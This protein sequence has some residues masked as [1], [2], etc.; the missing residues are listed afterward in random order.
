M[1][2]KRDAAVSI[3]GDSNLVFARRSDMLLSLSLLAVL[4]VL[5]VPLPPML[6]DMLLALNLGVSV[7]LLLITLNAKQPLDLSVF[8]S[9]LLLTTLYRLS[10]NVATTRLILLD[11]N[12]GR[13]VATFGNFVVGGSLV[14]GLV[15]FLILV[16]IQ[17]LVITKGASRISEVNARFTL[18]ALPG[19][20]MAID[21][22]LSSGGIDES[23]ARRRRQQLS[24]EMEFYG[25][26]DGAAKYVRGDSIAGLLI[27]AVNLI[28]GIVL[29]LSRGSTI[30]D[31]VKDYSV[32]TI[33]D[34]LVSQIPALIIATTSGILVTKAASD[35][36]L[37]EEL[38]SQFLANP[39][40]LWFGVV[41][42]TAISFVPGLPS[43]PFLL[44]A[45]GLVVYLRRVRSVAGPAAQAEEPDEPQHAG[46][47]SDEEDLD[48][49]L[50]HERLC[51]E[52]GMQLIPLV[53]PEGKK[54]IKDRIT[55]LRQDFSRRH[56]LWV[57]FVRIRDNLALDPGTYRILIGG[58]EVT[59]GELRP[60]QFLAIAAGDKNIELAGEPTK[61]PAFGLAAKWIS[62]GER[63]RAE[64]AGH[65][66]VDASSVLITHL[67]EVIRRHAHEL[68]GREDLKKMLDRL[69]EHAPSL[70]EELR[71]ELIRMGVLH[72][73]LVNLVKE[74]VS[75]S[76]LIMIVESVVHH[77]A[78]VKDTTALTEAVRHDIA[79][80]ICDRFRDETGRIRVI[81]L[82]P[83]LEASLH[84]LATD[85]G[86]SFRA[87]Q[88]ERFIA[89]LQTHWQKAV[90]Q[91]QAVALLTD[92]RLRRTIRQTIER[93]LP[94]LSV[95]A[96][97]EIPGDLLIEPLAMVR[98]AEVEEAAA[99]K[100][101]VA[102]DNLTTKDASADSVAEKV[103]A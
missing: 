28:G 103:A 41:V 65:T 23:E 17:F 83:R 25:A 15:V 88:L 102:D 85:R 3:K 32:L 8:P 21:A 53:A 35:A 87:D 90:L 27:T 29:A 18:D 19:R 70:V 72:Q 39:R 66:V 52:I 60:D 38:G 22:E 44:L 13:I 43:F 1:D 14:V 7:L 49:F 71:P 94:E 50:Q 97:N 59:R 5:L 99:R 6:L 95:I 10:L 2:S 36:S 55:S 84:D 47:P 78:T 86:I 26:M 89:T 68:L 92:G 30:P 67:G 73:V 62:V 31:A 11:G 100:T 51:L 37:G 82:D 93:S 45:G 12:A 46:K 98:L 58:R 101:T 77:A 91:N 4:V 16:L 33:G 74:G 96:Y 48:R 69:K 40:P 64:V 9:F 57:P 81:V 54:G 56:G 79:R 75:I 34:G 42:L 61:D 80:T 20:Q 76:N 63:R 24:R